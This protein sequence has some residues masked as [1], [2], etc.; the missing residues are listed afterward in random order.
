MLTYRSHVYNLAMAV[1]AA[2]PYGASNNPLKTL[3]SVLA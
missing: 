1:S 3:S 2:L